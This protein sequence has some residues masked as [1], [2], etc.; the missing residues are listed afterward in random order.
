MRPKVVSTDTVIPSETRNGIRWR[1]FQRDH[2][3]KRNEGGSIKGNAGT[4]ITR[5][6]HDVVAFFTDSLITLGHLIASSRI[7]LSD[8]PGRR[9]VWRRAV[10]S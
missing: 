10:H 5:T 7:Q 1:L 2:G 9:F 8:L 3:A 6:F 4:P